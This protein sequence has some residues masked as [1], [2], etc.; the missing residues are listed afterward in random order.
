MKRKQFHHLSYED[1]VRIEV[2]HA[3]GRSIRAI[4][5]IL[6]CSPNT[7]SYELKQKKVSGTYTAVKAQQKTYVRRYMSKQEC[8]KVHTSG[9][10]V[11]IVH[12]LHTRWSPERI[13]GYFKRKGVSVSKNAI[14]TFVYK[15]SYDWY[16]PYRGRKKKRGWN[17]SSFLTGERKYIE[18]RVVAPQSGHYEADFIVSSASLSVL[19]V[20]V[21]KHTRYTMIRVLPNKKHTTVTRAFAHIFKGCRV[22]SLTLD[23]DISFSHWKSLEILLATS[24]Y[25]THPYHSWEKGLV[26]NTNRWIRLYF[27]P[28]K[29]DIKTVTEEMV[30]SMNHFFNTVPRQ[31]LDY[32]TATDM[33][34]LEKEVS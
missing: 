13:S 7:V 18:E 12:K 34:E 10:Q 11:Q 9:M 31:C 8:L 3:E 30:H 28:K 33:V 22:R 20:V 14:Y 5:R 23:N 32:R 15:R 25:F 2:L 29:Q 21:D 4:A 1:R 19:L 16:L 24:I 26:E 27:V 6:S 17:T